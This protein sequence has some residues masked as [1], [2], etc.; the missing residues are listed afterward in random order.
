M[1]INLKLFL[2]L[3]YA[4]LGVVLLLFLSESAQGF[5][6]IVSSDTSLG[7][8]SSY[9]DVWIDGA[10]LYTNDYRF[11]CRKLTINESGVLEANSS[12]IVTSGKVTHNGYWAAVMKDLQD[13]DLPADNTPAIIDQW[14]RD[15][16]Y[17]IID[18]LPHWQVGGVGLERV[19]QAAVLRFTNDYYERLIKIGKGSWERAAR[20]VDEAYHHQVEGTTLKEQWRSWRDKVI[21]MDDEQG[22]LA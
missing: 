19:R 22:V 9:D 12:D 4:C 14:H 21:P 16:G 1:S 17:L 6:L 11:S 13:V 7:V 5:D 10:T 8:D 20:K 15:L 18:K 3:A 2:A